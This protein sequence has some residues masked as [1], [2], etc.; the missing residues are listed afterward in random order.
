MIVLIVALLLT[1]PVTVWRA[2]VAGILWVWFVTPA[3]GLPAPPLWIMAGL[4]LMV[5]MTHQWN[6]KQAT[7]DLKTDGQRAGVMLFMSV[8][9]PALT[10]FFGWLIHLLAG[11]V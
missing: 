10:L 3:F 2:Y 9:G 5:H 6:I 8:L 7:D 4:F 11:G 1:L